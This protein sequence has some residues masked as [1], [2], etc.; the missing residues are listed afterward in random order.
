[1]RFVALF[2][3]AMLMSFAVC[4]ADQINTDKLLHPVAHG[5]GS[6]VL[7]HIGEVICVKATDLDKTTCSIISGV[8]AT[9]AGIAVEL[10][11]DQQA[12]NWK[13]GV[14]YDVSGVLLAIGVI[15]LDF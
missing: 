13:K 15:H 10:L 9:S 6:Y 5:A 11:Q 1:M 4:Y 3:L 8:V 12:G 14:A 2:T 7:T